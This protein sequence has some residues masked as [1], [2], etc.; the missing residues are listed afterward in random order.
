[1]NNILFPILAS[2]LCLLGAL[3]FEGPRNQIA[4]YLA[5]YSA[6]T[7]AVFAADKQQAQAKKVRVAE[8]VLLVFAALGGSIAMAFGIN[9]LRHKSFKASYQFKYGLIIILQILI[10]RFAFM[11]LAK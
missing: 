8:K 5:A 1:M 7:L 2:V 6:I 11:K 3:F 4:V 10:I 9:F